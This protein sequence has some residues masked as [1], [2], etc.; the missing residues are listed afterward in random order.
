MVTHVGI[1]GFAQAETKWE[2]YTLG[3]DT[4]SDIGRVRERG[5]NP[6]WI[7]E[8][9]KGLAPLGNKDSQV[10]RIREISSG[11]RSVNTDFEN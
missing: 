6:S 1:L 2:S 8:M 11:D 9:G 10:Y 7:N 4:K 3:F 5:G